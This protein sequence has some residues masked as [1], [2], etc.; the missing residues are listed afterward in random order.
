VGYEAGQLLGHGIAPARRTNSTSHYVDFAKFFCSTLGLRFREVICA[1]VR[2]RLG[3]MGG[4][5]RVV[6]PCAY[7]GLWLRIVCHD[8]ATFM[9]DLVNSQ[10]SR[11]AALRAAS[12]NTTKFQPSNQRKSQDRD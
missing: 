8:H 10:F 5:I 3:L 1:I 2:L 12:P 7:R 4:S 9:C 11:I 6:V